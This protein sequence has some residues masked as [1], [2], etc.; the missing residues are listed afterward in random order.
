MCQLVH[1]I[2]DRAAVL[3]ERMVFDCGKEGLQVS[4]EVVMMLI[5][6]LRHKKPGKWY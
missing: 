3:P 6:S 5:L 1:R 4:R 2:K